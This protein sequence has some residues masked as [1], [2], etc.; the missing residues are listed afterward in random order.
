[1]GRLRSCAVMAPGPEL[2]AMLPRHI[3]ATRQQGGRDVPNPDWLLFDDLVLRD[4]LATEH[5][6]MCSAIAAVADEVVD[7]RGWLAEI[8]ALPDARESLLADIAGLEHQLRPDLRGAVDE[9]LRRLA[10][11]AP[12]ALADALLT[13]LDPR[14]GVDV[15]AFPT[16][17]W[18]FARD[19]WAGIGAAIVVGWPRVR[20][21]WRDGVLA[22]ALLVHHPRLRDVPRLD[23]RATATGMGA[24]GT[25]EG[26][27]H[28]CI[29]GGDV[30]V[31]GPD[32]ALIGIGAR[33]TEAAAA[34]LAG[35]LRQR[36]SAR[37]LGVH[38]PQRR[39]TMH[40]DT[41]FTFLDQ[42]A[43]VAHAPAFDRRADPA[44]RVTVVDL[45]APEVSL[46]A[47]L[48]AIVR[49]HLGGLDI[50]VCG[51]SDARSAAREQ[52]TDGANAFAL[53]PGIVLLYARNAAT[54]QAL[55]R[56]GFEIVGS[57]QF[58]EEAATRIARGQRTVVALTG[59]ELS[60]GRGGPRC[61]TLPL[62]RARLPGATQPGAPEPAPA[63]L[64]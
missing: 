56:A 5:A 62:G 29:E 63:L 14:D 20:A 3:E 15:L 64:R 34:A 23:V 60:R 2:D 30:L 37:V 32:L 11:L 4:L 6:E 55:E 33:T 31:A 58:G 10:D 54:L 42:H 39:A 52:W 21:R 50:V 26:S 44:E 28:L 49:E 38:L 22:R 40:L 53:A 8:L 46:G 9:G 25:D 27:A 43:V 61:L 1:M 19:L 47:D 17:N 13:G 12:S 45:A 57:A 59:A 16:P 35:L 41:V 36:G 18:L 7:L 24:L 48:P 51:G